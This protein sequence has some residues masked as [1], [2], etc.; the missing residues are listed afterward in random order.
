MKNSFDH[1]NAIQ[2]KF[3]FAAHDNCREIREH[4]NLMSLKCFCNS[5][6]KKSVHGSVVTGTFIR[7]LDVCHCSKS[8]TQ[9][10]DIVTNQE[11]TKNGIMYECYKTFALF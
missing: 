1:K 2:S 8:V 7:V 9:R 5:L 3:L 10:A 4:N 11:S 6:R